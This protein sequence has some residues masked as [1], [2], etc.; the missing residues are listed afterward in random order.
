[1]LVCCSLAAQ[2]VPCRL[3]TPRPACCRLCSPKPVSRRGR[4]Q[5]R[6]TKAFP[7][8]SPASTSRASPRRSTRKAPT[9]VAAL[10]AKQPPP[11]AMTPVSLQLPPP[12]PS[13]LPPLTWTSQSSQAWDSADDLASTMTVA[14]GSVLAPSQEQEDRKLAKAA[15]ASGRRQP[16]GSNQAGNGAFPG[17]GSNGSDGLAQ[18]AGWEGEGQQQ[19]SL[20]RAGGS[21]DSQGEWEGA[22]AVG[23]RQSASNT[24]ASRDAQE[25]VA[26]RMQEPIPDQ[27]KAT[28]SCGMACNI[29]SLI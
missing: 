4:C 1:M 2:C 12:L 18:R 26:V 8:S 11:P 22:G 17:N 19:A 24:L 14:E 10:K 29:I 13:A 21:S 28:P 23:S 15:E 27:P 20:E 9:A 5:R 16:A 3:L 6:S 25:Q 7:A